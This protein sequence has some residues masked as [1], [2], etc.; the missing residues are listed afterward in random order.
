MLKVGRSKVESVEITGFGLWYAGS[1][2]AES[3]QS[4]QVQLLKLCPE[5]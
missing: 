2:K 1:E 3:A 4:G 5:F